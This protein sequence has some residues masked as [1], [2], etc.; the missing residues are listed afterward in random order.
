ML[1][2]ERYMDSFKESIFKR[3]E[4]QEEN[5]KNLTDKVKSLEVTQMEYKEITSKR[6]SRLEERRNEGES[7]DIELQQVRNLK[8]LFFFPIFYLKP[9]DV[10]DEIQI[11]KSVGDKRTSREIEYSLFSS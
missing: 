7:E 6:L 5:F 8:Y 11:G 10:L 3:F 9:F 4:K 2:I 1:D